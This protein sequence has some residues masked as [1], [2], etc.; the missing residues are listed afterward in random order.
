MSALNNYYVTFGIKYRH[1]QHPHWYSAQPDG[2]LE[3]IA[4]DYE[5]ARALVSR[6]IGDAFAFMYEERAFEREWYPLDRLA[7][8]TEDGV[9]WP[10]EG[11]EPP[12]PIVETRRH[13]SVLVTW[14][15]TEQYTAQVEV[16]DDFDLEEDGVD[17]RLMDLINDLSSEQMDRASVGVTDKAI[18]D[19]EMYS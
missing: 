5:A 19:K 15:Q 8:L 3:V 14:Y 11:V 6:Y 10:K 9:L 17:E 13:K 16:D 2:W 1:E 4:T 18:T 12:T 7:T